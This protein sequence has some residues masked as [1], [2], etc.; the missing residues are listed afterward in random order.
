MPQVDALVHWIGVVLV[1]CVC[2]GLLVRALRLPREARREPACGGCG[3][4]IGSGRADRCPE[5]GRDY[6]DAGITTPS[7]V[8]RL[9]GGLVWILAAWAGLVFT[10]G[11]L[12]LGHL[13]QRAMMRSFAAAMTS[14]RDLPTGSWFLHPVRVSPGDHRWYQASVML[15]ATTFQ[16]A[17]ESGS[18]ALTVR[19]VDADKEAT[20]S[21]DLSN[22]AFEGRTTTGESFAKGS[23]VD[24]TAV[25]KAFAA[26][27]LTGPEV[28]AEVDEAARRVVASVNQ[29]DSADQ[30][31]RAA[32]SNKPDPFQVTGS[33]TTIKAGPVI[34]S[35]A[36]DREP[37]TGGLAL[38]VVWLAGS[39][40]LWRRLREA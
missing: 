32:A 23:A 5:C 25:A 1:L 14:R 38:V 4:P 2:A 20:L 22:R 24:A 21:I 31:M 10:G 30:A 18:L 36:W 26:A 15:N 27:G 11:S 6:T 8:K 39:G 29:P 13:S 40:V 16:G 7:T 35:A 17:P 33:F 28:Q 9:R 37:V 3:Y 19:G 12:L 34:T